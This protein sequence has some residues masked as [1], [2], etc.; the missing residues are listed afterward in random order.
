MP[1]TTALYTAM[2][3]LNANS[4][5]I[6]VIGN[7]IANSNTTA[8]KSSKLLFSTMFSRTLSG[9]TPPGDINGGTNPYQIGLGVNTAGTLRNTGGGTI[10]G[11]G[12]QR[13]LAIDGNGHFVVRRGTEQLYTRAGSFRP[14]ARNE[15]V[16]ISG[17]HLQGYGVDA[18]FNIVQGALTD[19]SIPLGA[20]TIAEP[21]SHVRFSGNL[22]ADGPLPGRGASIALTGSSA[23]LVAI[24][25]ASPAPGTGHRVEDTTRLVDIEDPAN[26]GSDTPRFAAGQ[27]LQVRGAEKGTRTLPTATLDITATTTLADLTAFLASALG[28]QTG[29]GNN[30]DGGTPGVSVDPTSGVVTITGNSGRVNDLSLE[31]TDLRLLDASGTLIGSPLVSTKSGSADGESVRTSFVVYDSLGASVNVDIT[32]ALDTRDNTGTTWRY[33]VESPD[34]TDVPLQVGTGTISFDTQGRISTTAPVTVNI[35]RSGTGAASPL[36][37][38]FAFAGDGDSGLT[39]L[40]DSSSAVAATFRDGS[41]I[42][43]LTNFGVGDDGTIVGGFSN[44]LTRPLGQIVLAT[45]TNDAGLEDIGSNLFRTGANSGSAVVGSPGQ[46]NAGRV[47]GGALEQSNVDLSDEFIKLVL[48]STGFSANSRVIRTTDELLQQL[49]VLGR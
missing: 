42:G 7:N 37:I 33:Y 23:G 35:D 1:S 45:F 39:A 30:P 34:A 26:P 9:G 32:L 46:F 49:M 41:P 21:T 12:D 8:F 22:D 28:I 16:T 10:T 20:L 5:N 4:R 6:D 17:E 38:E 3:G 18:N 19:L 31:A 14:N 25:T 11:T 27:T 43:T 15:L 48:S 47:V 40:A 36:T 13:D 44:G 24:T 29:S 2:T